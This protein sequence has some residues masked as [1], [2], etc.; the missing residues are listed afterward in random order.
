M[1]EFPESR[2]VRIS[3]TDKIRVEFSALAVIAGGVMLSRSCG[4]VE[5]FDCAVKHV[6]EHFRLPLKSGRRLPQHDEVFLPSCLRIYHWNPP[7]RSLSN[8]FPVPVCLVF[9]PKP[10]ESKLRSRN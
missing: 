9:V 7:V 5:P 2:G 4:S 6:R 10:G 8:S 1:P 3:G